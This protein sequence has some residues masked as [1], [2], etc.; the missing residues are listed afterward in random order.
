M[1]SKIRVIENRLGRKFIISTILLQNAKQEEIGI[2]QPDEE[3]I[4]FKFDPMFVV[5]W[6]KHEYDANNV[7]DRTLIE[8]SNGRASSIN[9]TVKEFEKVFLNI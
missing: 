8:F 7:W 9:C 4:E 1:S 3:E 5:S 6:Y 2:K